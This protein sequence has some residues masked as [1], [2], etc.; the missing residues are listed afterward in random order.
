MDETGEIVPGN[1]LQQT[2]QT[3]K[4]TTR[5]LKSA[6]C[7]L[8]Q[9]VKVN[10]WLDDTRDF[11]SFNCV[12]AEYFSNAPLLSLNWRLC[13]L[14]RRQDQKECNRL[15]SLKGLMSNPSVPYPR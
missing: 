12:Y 8:P 1:I 3:I 4:N 15:Q 11:W 6:N 7:D 14:D 9:F 13:N 10:V 5:V 2:R